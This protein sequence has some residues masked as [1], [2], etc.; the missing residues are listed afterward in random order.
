MKKG[1]WLFTFMFLLFSIFAYSQEAKEILKKSA[2]AA[3]KIPDGSYEMIHAWKPMT[4][5]DTIIK[6]LKTDFIKT[7]N[8]S[9]FPVLFKLEE[10]DF[11]KW[12][13][14]DELIW[15]NK[16]EN[17]ATILSRQEHNDFIFRI[18]NNYILFKPITHATTFYKFIDEQEDII[19]TIAE[20][21]NPSIAGCVKVSIRYA[22]TY[23]SLFNASSLNRYRHL[24]IDTVSYLPVRYDHNVDIAMNNDT[25]HQYISVSLLTHSFDTILPEN[26]FTINSLHKNLKLKDYSPEKEIPLLSKGEIAPDWNLKD[27]NG[28]ASTLKGYEGKLVLIDFFYKSCFPCLK[29]IPFLQSLHE[30][31]NARGLAVIGIDPYDKDENDL[32]TF[33]KKRGV[34][35]KVLLS[36]NTFPR[37]YN[38]TGYPTLY[39]IDKTGK[40]IYSHAG[41]SE[42]MEN[43]LEE[44]IL[45]NL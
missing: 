30:K 36:E 23:D 17:T 9:I 1:Y 44:V 7:E 2:E 25:M 22:D 13:T 45:K 11:S 5:K 3:K 15:I 41:Y 12:Y 40:I 24:W 14:G 29:A 35:Y 32:K 10:T 21:K 28:E 19:Y 18:K 34:T 37:E 20:N 6:I 4:E 26:H 31:Y 16:T 8:D 43:A 33:L 42:E 27:L 38:V 39:I